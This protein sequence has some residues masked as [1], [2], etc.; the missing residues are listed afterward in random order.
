MTVYTGTQLEPVDV[1]VKGGS[2]A[3]LHLILAPWPYETVSRRGSAAQCAGRPVA[4][5]QFLVAAGRRNRAVPFRHVVML[6]TR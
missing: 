2:A 6:P 5:R 1:P 4:E 3:F